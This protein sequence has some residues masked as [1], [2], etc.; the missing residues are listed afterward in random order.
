[1]KYNTLEVTEQPE[2]LGFTSI[3][4]LVN[5]TLNQNFGTGIGLGSVPSGFRELDKHTG[6]FQKGNLYTIAVRPGMGKTAFLL[7]LAANMAIKDDFSVAVFSSE[8]SDMKMTQ[9]LI[10]SETGMSVEKLRSGRFRESRKAQLHSLLSSI[11]KAKIFIDDTPGLSLDELLRKATL[12]KEQQSADII[13]I[14]YLELLNKPGML[15]AV[16]TDY[17]F[18]LQSVRALAQKLDVPVVLF[19]QAR[20]SSNGSGLKERYGAIH[21]PASMREISDVLLLLHRNDTF[22][23]PGPG[24]KSAVELWVYNKPGEGEEVVIPLHFI[25]SI[26]KFADYP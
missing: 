26:A 22:H 1:M 9:R 16:E 5:Q 3:R 19:S 6:G 17:A 10:E 21:L 24:N 12:L 18:V 8:R 4:D 15:D 2:G 20:I 7:S 23:S 14:D 13:I 11:A 25:D